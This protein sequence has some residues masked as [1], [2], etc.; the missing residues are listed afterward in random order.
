[1][2][3]RIGGELP[4]ADPHMR[5]TQVPGGGRST[6]VLMRAVPFGQVTVAA[7]GVPLRCRL[8]VEVSPCSSLST[9]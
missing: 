4:P 1:M 5:A 9:V 3:P 2:G 6:V 8:G 7:W